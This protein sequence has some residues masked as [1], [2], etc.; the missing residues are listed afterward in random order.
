MKIA[1][2]G[3]QHSNISNLKNLILKLN[4]ENINRFIQV[5]DLNFTEPNNL[6]MK[7][8]NQVLSINNSKLYFIDGNYDNSNYLLEISKDKFSEC[9]I[10]EYIYY[11]PRGSYK[12]IGDKNF[13]FCGGAYSLNKNKKIK[14]N[15]YYSRETISDDDVTNIKSYWV[16]KNINFDFFISHDTIEPFNYK[17]SKMPKL[18]HKTFYKEDVK[19]RQNLKEIFDLTNSKNIIHGHFHKISTLGIYD[20]S[21]NTLNKDSSNFK[22]QYMILSV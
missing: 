2:I 6:F 20:I 21:N 18:I 9:K 3:D 1:V 13:F 12:R 5:G 8:L 11:M 14:N 4:K 7:E 16:D 19:H 10:S 15:L 22:E 17:L